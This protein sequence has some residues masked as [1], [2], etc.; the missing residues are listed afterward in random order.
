MAV[1][2]GFV[3]WIFLHSDV[4]KK[5]YKME[6]GVAVAVCLFMHNARLFQ[7]S[8]GFSQGNPVSHSLVNWHNCIHCN[9]IKIKIGVSHT[10][11]Q[12]KL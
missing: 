9:F 8:L 7:G 4:C 2:T 6:V 5:S 12:I 3:I 11:Y 1:F 10:Y